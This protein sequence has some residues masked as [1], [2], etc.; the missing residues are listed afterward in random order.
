MA[1]RPDPC[2]LPRDRRRCIRNRRDGP[3]SESLERSWRQDWNL[4]FNGIARAQPSCRR[5][6][7]RNH[8]KRQCFV[9][10]FLPENALICP[11]SRLSSLDLTAAGL[12]LLCY[13][14]LNRGG[15]SVI[16]GD[17]L[18]RELDDPVAPQTAPDPR[19]RGLARP[20]MRAFEWLAGKNRE[21]RRKA[22]AGALIGNAAASASRSTAAAI[23]S[24]DASE[25]RA[26]AAERA[27]TRAT[28]ALIVSAISFAS[29]IVLALCL[30]A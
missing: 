27:N 26:R 17:S 15:E 5:N 28:I 25:W 8:T 10:T 11:P 24:S 13:G 4:S 9:C 12:I 1:R 30:F 23:R 16:G 20:A 22:D 21:I 14:R 2:N 6:C 29:A 18:A 3:M 19:A 7:G